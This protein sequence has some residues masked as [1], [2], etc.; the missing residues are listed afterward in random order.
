MFLGAGWVGGGEVTAG[1]LG[2]LSIHHLLELSR[3]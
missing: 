3:I 2:L 1:I